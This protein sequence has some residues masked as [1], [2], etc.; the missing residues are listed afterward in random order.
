MYFGAP[1]AVCHATADG[2]TDAPVYDTLLSLL[3][4]NLLDLTDLFLNFASYPF[5]GTFDFLLQLLRLRLGFLD[6]FFRFCTS[7]GIKFL[8]I[9]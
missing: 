7:I 9:L 4:K 5:T 3:P 6:E 1:V 8:C 2:G